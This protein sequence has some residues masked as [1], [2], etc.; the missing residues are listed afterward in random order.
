MRI[1]QD[2]V[3]GDWCYKFE[4]DGAVYTEREFK[5]QLDAKSTGAVK[6]MQVIMGQEFIPESRESKEKGLFEPDNSIEKRP[7]KKQNP[8]KVRPKKTRKVTPKDNL[9][10]PTNQV[11][12]EDSNSESNTQN[13]IESNT[14]KEEFILNEGWIPLFRKLLDS[15]VFQS[16][17]L[18]K[19]WIWCLLKVAYKARWVPVKINKTTTEV[20]LFAGQ[21]IFG[22]KTAAKE[23]KMKP[24]TAWKRMQKLE[25]MQNLNIQSNRHYSVVTLANWKFYQGLLKKVTA[26]VT[27]REQPGNTNKKDKKEKNNKY[28]RNFLSFWEAYPNRKAKKKAHEAWQKLDK[29]EDMEILLPTLLDTIEKQKQSKEIQKSKGEFVSEWPHPATWLN[30]RRWEDEIEIKKRWDHATG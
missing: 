29:N 27:A 20:H 3:K 10:I 8:D 22:R 28:A 15:Q 7:E 13:N 5:S 25:N 1:W 12:K 19:V 6:E 17:G 11:F 21:F 18:L 23:L 2:K 30:G 9:E 16:E 4:Y 14:Q 26:K 24:S